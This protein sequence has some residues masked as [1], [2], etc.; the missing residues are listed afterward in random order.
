[1]SSTT[2]TTS[3]ALRTLAHDL[4]DEQQRW[5]EVLSA[6]PEGHWQRPTPAV[7]WDIHDQLA[8]VALVEEHAVAALA[9]PDGFA[10]TVAHAAAQSADFERELYERGR[11]HSS[12]ELLDRWRR[13]RRI[14]RQR[15]LEAP[16]G[17]RIAWFGPPM[18]ARSFLTAR[19]ME[20]WSHGQDVRDALGLPTPVTPALRH[21]AE[22]GVRTLAWSYRV[23]DLE[24]DP[25]PVHVQ[26]VGAAAQVWR[27]HDPDLPD[28]VRGSA[29]DFCLVVTQRRHWRDTGLEVEGPAATRWMEL[30]QAFAGPPTLA[31]R[32]RGLGEGTE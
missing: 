1:M 13:A 32:G 19:L 11:T 22:L 10:A 21:I 16:A 5:D 7:G 25:R 18:S 4:Q 6:L 3:E 14:V 15:A 29:L 2:A 23:R 27:W 17:T 20:T 8:H 28:R 30:A 12:A 26:L 9:D 24:P 31:A